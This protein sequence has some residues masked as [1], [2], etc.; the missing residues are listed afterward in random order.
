MGA[1]T[2][3]IITIATTTITTT[4]T[5]TSRARAGASVPG[6]PAYL[7]VA[8]THALMATIANVSS[9]ATA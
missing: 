3:T 6:A 7:G 2:T 4:T 8:A 9:D 1:I 5:T